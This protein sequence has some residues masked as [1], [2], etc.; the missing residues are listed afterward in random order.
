MLR[1]PDFVAIS[2]RM[3]ERTPAEDPEPDVARFDVGKAV[4]DLAGPAYRAGVDPGSSEALAIVERLEA[5]GATPPEDRRRIAERIEAFTDRRVG[6]YWTLVG[7]VNGWRPSAAPGDIV[8]AWEWYAEA[9]RA[10]A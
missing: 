5:F 2:R 6:R 9:L 4:G 1:D 8:D 3:A 7:I 10:H